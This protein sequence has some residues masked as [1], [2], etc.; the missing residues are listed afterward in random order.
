MDYYTRKIKARQLIFEEKQ[1]DSPKDIIIYKLEMKY[2]LGKKFY[3]DFLELEK[4]A[5]ESLIKKEK[6]EKENKEKQEKETFEV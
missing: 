5:S 1:A 3:N 2:G 6:K 4:S